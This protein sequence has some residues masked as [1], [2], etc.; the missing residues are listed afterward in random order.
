MIGQIKGRWSRRLGK[1]RRFQE[2]EDAEEEGEKRNRST[3]L[4]ETAGSKGSHRCA[5]W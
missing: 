3:W 2:R 1:R 4:E 5:R